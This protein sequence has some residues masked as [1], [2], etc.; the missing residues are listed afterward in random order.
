LAEPEEAVN[1]SASLL[2]LYSVGAI[3]GPLIASV[4]KQQYGP[5]TLFLYTAIIHVLIAL[6]VWYRTTQRA[7]PSAEER[8]VYDDLPINTTPAGFDLTK[9]AA[10]DTPA[11][12]DG[13]ELSDSHPPVEGN[14]KDPR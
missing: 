6:A 10:S 5:G 14:L 8:V 11:A 3:F 4:L 1:I 2:M 9:P 13:L 12:S 7:R